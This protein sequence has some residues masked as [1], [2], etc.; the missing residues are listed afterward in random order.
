MYRSDV[1]KN[2]KQ[3]VDENIG[4]DNEKDFQDKQPASYSLLFNQSNLTTLQC[5]CSHSQPDRFRNY[6][7]EN[8]EVYEDRSR[9][10]GRERQRSRASKGRKNRSKRDT[11]IINVG[12]QIFETYRT[13]LSRLRTPV[14]HSDDKMELY[15]RKS[16]DD[17]F[18]DR[19]PIAFGSI[20][21]FLRTG[22]L[23]IPTNMCG[24]ALQVCS[25]NSNCQKNNSLYPCYLLC[26]FKYIFKGSE[27]YN[28]KM[29]EDGNVNASVV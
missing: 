5:S 8:E 21:N 1:L 9:R 16:H 26:Y 3:T 12:G 13:T 27:E 7:D 20:L 22:E 10:N 29:Q 15:Y 28:A 17:Y 14:F 23:H 2:E 4:D 18:F 19:D 11:V 24:P 6:N 25:L